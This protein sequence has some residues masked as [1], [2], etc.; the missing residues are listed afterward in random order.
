M[1]TL[2]VAGFS[3]F[4]YSFAGGSLV[5]NTPFALG[6]LS[7]AHVQAYVVG[8]LDGLGNQIY[9]A[10]TY[11][12]SSG[13]TTV[14]GP[15]P[16][17]CDVVLQRTV[18][19]N[20][21]FVSFASG[22][23]VTRTNIDVA[24]KYTLMALHETL[25]GRWS[26]V[27]F[28]ALSDAVNDAIAVRDAALAAMYASQ[29]SQAAAEAWA[30]SPTAP[31]AFDLTSKSAKTW[32]REAAASAANAALYDDIW[33]DDVATVTS[34]TVLSYIAG[35]GKTVVTSGKYILTRKECRS[36]QVVAAGAVTYDLI[37]AGG[38]KL[39]LRTSIGNYPDAISYY[40]GKDLS[41]HTATMDFAS[42]FK[43]GAATTSTIRRAQAAGREEFVVMAGTTAFGTGS[44][45]AGVS[46]Y[47]NADTEHP[48]AIHIMT[49]DN[50]AGTSRLGI[51]Q[52]GG[53]VMGANVYGRTNE[54]HDGTNPQIGYLN[55]FDDWTGYGADTK[56]G[57]WAETDASTTGAQGVMRA[58]IGLGWREGSQ[59]LHSGEGV[60]LGYYAR[61]EADTMPV[62]V[63]EA[64]IEKFNAD[65]FSRISNYIIKVSADGI[66]APVQRLRISGT[67]G[68]VL[69]GLLNMQGTPVYAD[70][71]A[72]T[73]GGLIAGDVYR[74]STG[75][76]MIRY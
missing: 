21:L 48:G 37:T 54:M 18:P 41:L 56:L 66:A 32:A 16:N 9:R 14:V 40:A 69:I 4:T 58:K 29:V 53:I 7:P 38:V 20:T 71:A 74:T 51:T 26:N 46:F 12:A 15:L 36:Y 62:L 34:D 59:N 67:D 61:L 76:L 55:I 30:Q 39:A 70:N 43:G 45:G 31:D 17:P 75:V 50:G 6:V 8:E 64:G 63:A 23:D 68:K 27:A 11:S 28:D 19:K 52:D 35:A 33:L 72:A 65:D 49:G 10:C 5:F 47:G 13:V 57:I 25:D 22:A 73:T 60:S 44:N 24:V 2:S 42:S 1:A 3:T